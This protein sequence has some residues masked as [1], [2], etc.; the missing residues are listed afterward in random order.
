[1]LRKIA[2]ILVL[3]AFAVLMGERVVPHHHCGEGFLCGTET[4]EIHFGYGEC[5]HSHCDDG[6]SHDEE[7]CCDEVE[8]YSRPSDDETDVCKAILVHHPVYFALL[9]QS[10]QCPVGGA[11]LV[12]N[13]YILKIPDRGVSSAS[14][15]APPVA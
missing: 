2:Y 10:S 13:C 4:A 12:E 15:R 1:M 5:G 11:V 3:M 14:L 9:S 6:H 7:R 8:Y